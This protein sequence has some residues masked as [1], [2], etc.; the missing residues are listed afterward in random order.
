MKRQRG[1]RKHRDRSKRAVIVRVYSYRTRGVIVAYP[2]VATIT[3][4]Y[5]EHTD[6]SGYRIV[7]K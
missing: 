7:N 2:S 3:S 6:L 1:H 4:E 5:D